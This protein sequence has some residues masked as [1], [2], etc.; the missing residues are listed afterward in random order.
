MERRWAPAP[1]E[2]HHMYYRLGEDP[3]EMRNRATEGGVDEH[4][5]SLRDLLLDW[6][7]RTPWGA[8]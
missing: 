7:A 5:A 3:Y 6:R 2:R 4:G 8:G 1:D